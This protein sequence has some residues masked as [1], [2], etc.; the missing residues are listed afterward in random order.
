MLERK[1][2]RITGRVQGVG[3]R[4][5]MVRWAQQCGCSG[6]VWNDTWGVVLEIQGVTA[7]ID[8]FL[9]GLQGEGCP[10]MARIQQIQQQDVP[11]AE[12]EGDFLIETSDATG[13][14]LAQVTADLALCPDCLQ[15]MRDAG[16][17]RYQYPFINCT[18]CG[19][20]YS[21]VKTVPYDRPNTTMSVFAMC[22]RCAEQYG[23]VTDRRFHAQ[24]VACPTCGPHAWLTDAQG[25]VLH[26]E[27]AAAIAAAAQLLHQGKIV[28]IKGVG[29][30]HLAVDAT[31]EDAV[32]RLRQRKRRDAKPF[33]VMAA[34]LEVIRR[35]AQVEPWAEQV[36]TSAEAPIVLLPQREGSSLAP[37]VAQ[38]V[39]RFGFMLC[40][41]PLHV[42]LFDQG[43]QLLVMT[44]ANLSDEPLICENDKALDRLGEVAD[45]FLMHD[46]AIYRQ[47]DDSIVHGIEQQP[48]VLRR[49]RGWVPTPIYLEGHE[50]PDVLAVGADLKN[51][52]CLAKQGRLICS[53]HMGDLA[54][55]EAYRHYRQSIDHLR[56]LFEVEP[57]VVVCDLHPGYFSTQYAQSLGIENLLQVQHHWAHVAAC[58]VEHQLTGPVIGLVAD[59]TGYGTDG[60]VWGGECL[61][62]DLNG[63]ERVGHLDYFSLP[64]GDQASREAIR[65]LLGLL[66]QTYDGLELNEWQWLLEPLEPDM[67]K[68]SVILAQ[69]QANLNCIQTSSLGRVFDA[70]ASLCGVGRV[71]GFDAQLP[72]ALEALTLNEPI[73][74]Y[75]FQWREDSDG[76]LRLDWRP[77]LRQII[78]QRRAQVDPR[79]MATAFHCT[80]VEV[81]SDVAR[82]IR[83]KRH[84]NQV[85]LSGGVFCNQFLLSHLIERLRA[86]QFEVNFHQQIPSND[87]GISVGQAAI[88]CRS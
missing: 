66:T 51:T 14:A 33:A 7:A 1:K 72:M 3:F 36:L 70:V 87:G 2:L 88:A 78:G 52:F 62:A 59:G 27:S 49:A 31:Q 71:N 55:A 5:A 24:P 84:I 13:T 23:E 40:Y 9:S 45:A 43:P 32:L 20:R 41:A 64:G 42:L 6:K 30:F 81:W 86:M 82:R 47:V 56:Q 65:P 74:S 35:Q 44:S 80:W 38:G 22:Q 25:Q 69:L 17:F 15:E 63:F 10:P 67:Q 34:S 53:E 26:D 8:A 50:G 76:T 73:S 37:S 54:D 77:M 16:D 68:Q 12:G 4:P 48:V 39:N 75:D 57:E 19:P 29:G 85:V 21:I 61:V 11:V 79:Q 83:E 18:H 58:M 28:A 46:R 60:A